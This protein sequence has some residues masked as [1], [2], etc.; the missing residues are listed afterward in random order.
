MQHRCNL[1]F[2]DAIN[3]QKLEIMSKNR[4]VARCQLGSYLFL[5]VF[6]SVFICVSI[7]F[8]LC[9]YL[10]L[11]V[12]LSVSICVS[13]SFYLCF[14]LQS[15]CKSWNSCQRIG[16]LPSS[17]EEHLQSHQAW[18]VRNVHTCSRSKRRHQDTPLMQW[19]CKSLKSCQRTAQISSSIEEH[20]QSHQAWGVKNVHICSCRSL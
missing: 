12:F 15:I 2:P 16:Q 10:F 1:C 18:R 20:L 5:F 11:F 7:C 9:F 4:T 14:Y 6:L 13:I 17:I 8:Y 3:W 19:I